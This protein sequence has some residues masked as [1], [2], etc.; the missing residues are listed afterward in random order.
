MENPG[1]GVNG[2]AWSTDGRRLASVGGG[3]EPAVRIWAGDS[4]QLQLRLNSPGGALYSVAFSPDG[5][6][7]AAAG[8]DGVIRVWNPSDGSLLQEFQAHQSAIWG[9]AFSLDGQKLYSASSDQTVCAWTAFSGELLWQENTGKR[10]YALALSRDGRW[11]A[12]GLENGGFWLSD[13]NLPGV[14]IVVP[15]EQI[16]VN[17]LAFHP[18]YPLL[19]L[20]SNQGRVLLY[21]LNMTAVV[22]EWTALKGWVLALAWNTQGDLLASGGGEGDNRV[23][24]WGR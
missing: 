13:L 4:G 5:S 24:I 9:L 22:N 23:I 15:L 3:S 12:A 11:L 8:K 17:S 19:A 7:L 6:Q 2:L 10:V 14:S 16:T 20:G 21:D 1:G 18:T